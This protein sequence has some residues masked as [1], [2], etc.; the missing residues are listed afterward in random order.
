M[1]P[2]TPKKAADTKGKILDAAEAL[3]ADRGFHRT[4]LREITASA[5]VNLASV[6]YHFGS[7]DQLIQAIFARRLGPINEARLAAL[8][9]LEKQPVSAPVPL[10]QLVESFVGPALRL[11]HQWDQVGPVSRLLGNVMNQ[12]D[13]RLKRQFVDQFRVVIE[14]YSTAL[15]R[16]LPNLSAEEI[17]WRFLFMAGLMAH[18]I[19]WTH[20]M[21]ALPGVPSLGT[22]IE[23]TI[24]H[25]IGF[26]CA[27]LRS[28]PP[29][30]PQT[31]RSR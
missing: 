6:N 29:V 28:D 5:G 14:R 31:G 23:A 20:D 11:C 25:L 10:E 4:S 19:L 18:T 9:R 21:P 8:D 12:P 2:V 7:K 13:A 24:E 16:A 22:D 27:G 15:S 26:T 3:F 1:S 30:R 17:H